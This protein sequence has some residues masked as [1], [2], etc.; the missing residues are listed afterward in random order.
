MDYKALSKILVDG[1]NVD[2]DG[3]PSPK[4]GDKVEL[5]MNRLLL[6]LFDYPAIM[7]FLQDASGTL[8]GDKANIQLVFGLMEPDG[9]SAVKNLIAHPHKMYR[10]DKEGAPVIAFDIELSP[11]DLKEVEIEPNFV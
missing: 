4:F 3:D 7:H 2:A 1:V 9:F 5:F 11:D 6:R 10:F 8:S